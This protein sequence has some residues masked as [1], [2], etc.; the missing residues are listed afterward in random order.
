VLEDVGEDTAPVGDETVDEDR[1]DTG[2]EVYGTVVKVEDLT[3]DRLDDPLDELFNW[4]LD[5]F[6][7]A[8]DEVF[9]VEDAADEDFFVETEDDLEP[10]LPNPAWHP[11]PQYASEVPQ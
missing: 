7:D 6:G 3:E 1:G 9:F 11:L 4:V 2:E 5:D 10:Q 8:V